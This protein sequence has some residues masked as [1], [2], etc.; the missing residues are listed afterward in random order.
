M[1]TCW[2]VGTVLAGQDC[3]RPLVS[4]VLPVH[5][6]AA[7][8]DEALMGIS[9]QTHRPLE[10]AV[11]DN[12]SVDA[13]PAILRKWEP[14]FKAVGITVTVVHTGPDSPQ[15]CGFARNR[16]IEAA[17]GA[18]SPYSALGASGLVR[19]CRQQ[20]RSLQVSGSA[21][22]MPTTSCFPVALSCSCAQLYKRHNTHFWAADLCDPTMVV[23]LLRSA[24]L[25][26]GST[27][28]E[29]SGWIRTMPHG[30]GRGRS[31]LPAIPGCGTHMVQRGA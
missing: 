23:C 12:C 21:L 26:C 7:H 2:H 11:C 29:A 5:N 24:L 16:A 13:S 19:I 1:C 28:N 6:D 17:T 31:C 15:S 25:E 18:I 9:L 20:D 27:A 4:V 3:V 8:L 14:K 22:L 30:H 10:L